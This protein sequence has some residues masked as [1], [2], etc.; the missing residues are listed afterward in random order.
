M[1]QI[2]R[3]FLMISSLMLTLAVYL[4]GHQVSLAPYVKSLLSNYPDFLDAVRQ[5]VPNAKIFSYAIYLLAC[6]LLSAFGFLMLRILPKERL[7]AGTFKSFEPVTDTFIPVYIAYF[8]VALGIPDLSTFWVLFA[9]IFVFA[10]FSSCVRFDP[11]Y[12]LAGYKV[13][14]GISNSDVKSYIITRTIIKNAK[15]VEFPNL[16]RVNDF[17][18]VDLEKSK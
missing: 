3:S 2:Y 7:D 5:H 17:T 8:F 1:I 4:I 14:A 13:Y 12:T 10:N 6:I 15:D 9:I 16:R 18:F 11:L